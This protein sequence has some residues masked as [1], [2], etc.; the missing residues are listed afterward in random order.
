MLARRV[1]ALAVSSAIALGTPGAT[2]AGTQEPPGDNVDERRK[3]ANRGKAEELY[4]EGSALYT[5]GDYQGAINAFTEAL[6]VVTREGGLEPEVRGGLVFNLA[7]A[8][9]RAH[10]I[11]RDI[12]HLRVARDLYKRLLAEADDAEYS[13]EVRA[14][15]QEQL[16]AVEDQLAEL[17][18]QPQPPPPRSPDP[19]TEAADDGAKPDKARKKRKPWTP[20]KKKRAGAIALLASGAAVAGGGLGVLIW[21]AR[22]KPNA[23]ASVGD[24]N[25]LT[26]NE[27]RRIEDETRR[28]RTFM[29]V[30][31]AI[32]AVGAG[33]IAGGAVLLSRTPKPAKGPGSAM[34]LRV[35]PV[36]GR[37]Y[38]GVTVGARF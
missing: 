33:M 16:T 23:E 29:G 11:D 25:N 38:T 22:L 35:E 20:E 14:R 24:P 8:H 2:F 6:K 32:M 9:V 31:G 18:K 5:A 15:T 12:T 27:E 19:G 7:Q 13:P 17:E 26:P 1:S 30:G 37:R 34:L 3:N 21:G 10:G 28:G 36:F 4:L